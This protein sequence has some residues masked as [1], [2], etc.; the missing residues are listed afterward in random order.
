MFAVTFN[1]HSNNRFIIRELNLAKYLNY[2]KNPANSLEF[3]F[4]NP[5]L[6]HKTPHQSCSTIH[7]AIFF[8]FHLGNWGSRY[9]NILLF[10]L[11]NFLIIFLFVLLY[12]PVYLVLDA[13]WIFF[14][15]ILSLYLLVHVLFHTFSFFFESKPNFLYYTLKL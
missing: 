11:L 2:F 10:L 6:F 8:S 3:F 5:L 4:S 9:I 12:P 1:Y 15:S 14:F 13:R 7:T